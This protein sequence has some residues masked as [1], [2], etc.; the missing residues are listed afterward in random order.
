MSIYADPFIRHHFRWL[1]V[2]LVGGVIFAELVYF[3]WFGMEG[4]LVKLFDLPEGDSAAGWWHTERKVFWLI[5]SFL[6]TLLGAK[7]VLRS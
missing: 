1:A 6:G 3:H 4:A 2:C 7:I 5:G